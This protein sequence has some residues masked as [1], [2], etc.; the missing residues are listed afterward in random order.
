MQ[1]ESYGAATEKVDN[2]SNR[3]EK[4]LSKTFPQSWTGKAVLI[5]PSQEV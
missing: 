2:A 3:F 5:K 4:P 1:S